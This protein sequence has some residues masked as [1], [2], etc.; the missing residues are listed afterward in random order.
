MLVVSRSAICNSFFLIKLVLHPFQ[1]LKSGSTNAKTAQ[2]CIKDLPRALYAV[3]C[4]TGK[5][6]T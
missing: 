5:D 2:Q 4:S 3:S 1:T 6:K